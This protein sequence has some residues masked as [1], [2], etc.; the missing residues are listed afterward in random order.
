MKYLT[1][2]E[3]KLLFTSG[4]CWTGAGAGL[5]AGGDHPFGACHEKLSL[6]RQ[7]GISKFTFKFDQF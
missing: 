2:L 6:V 3:N 7:A 4:G 1:T 5:G